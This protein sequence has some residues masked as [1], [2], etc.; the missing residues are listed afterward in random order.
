[1]TGGVRAIA[2]I[3]QLLLAGAGAWL[4][5][6]PFLTSAYGYLE[7]PP[8][9]EFEWA[10]AIAFDLGV[11]L[12][13]LGAVMLML[14]SLSRIARYAGETVNVEAM[15]YDPTDRVQAGKEER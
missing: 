1:M 14:Y 15:D 11:F 4:A 9:E 13:V 5:G 6:K 3:R 12:S 7:F 10:T 8:I 2:D